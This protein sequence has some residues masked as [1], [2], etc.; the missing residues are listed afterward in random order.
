MV[1][2][3]LLSAARTAAL[4]GAKA[5]IAVNVLAIGDDADDEAVGRWVSRMADGDGVSGELVQLGPGHLGK[6]LP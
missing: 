4:E 5:G 6:A 3:G 1:A 2:T